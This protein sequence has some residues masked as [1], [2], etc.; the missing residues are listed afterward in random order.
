MIAQAEANAENDKQRRSLIENANQADS[1]AADTEK[2][3]S[4]FREGLAQEEVTKLE[5]LLKELRELATRG[6]AGEEGLKAETVKE[7]MDEVQ[8]ASLG[9]FKKVSHQ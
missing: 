6:Q 4:E 8:N 7:K 3:L 2:A 9:V 5:D 1:V